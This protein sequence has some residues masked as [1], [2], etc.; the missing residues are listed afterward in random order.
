M[1]AFIKNKR[2]DQC[3]KKPFIYLSAGVSDDIFRESLNLAIS[4]DVNF[5]GVLC[6]RA[7]WK[8]GI[9]V[10]AKGGAQALEAWLL[11]RGVK[12]IQAL[13]AVLE[14]GAKPWHARYGGRDKVQGSGNADKK[15]LL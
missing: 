15:R 12:N 7:T 4:A 6:G 11:D 3:T 2:Q 8:D 9:P 14:K 5:A 13:N 10:Y 1:N